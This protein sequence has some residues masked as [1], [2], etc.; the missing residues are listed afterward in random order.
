[1][2]LPRGLRGESRRTSLREVSVNVG[3]SNTRGR[4]IDTDMAQLPDD[5][6]PVDDEYDGP[7][8][9]DD[10]KGDGADEDQGT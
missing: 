2:C 10:V 5:D 6:V 8:P 3:S 1:M 4:T 7:N 9:E